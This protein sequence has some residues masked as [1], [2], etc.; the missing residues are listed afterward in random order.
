M[1]E[2]RR[3]E[4]CT[5]V[6][7]VPTCSAVRAEIRDFELGVVSSDAEAKGSDGRVCNSEHSECYFSCTHGVFV[8][9]LSSLTTNSAL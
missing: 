6:D 5:R 2:K 8:E 7:T 1:C 9:F 3:V 4:D